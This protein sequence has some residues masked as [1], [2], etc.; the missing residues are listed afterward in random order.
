MAEEEHNETA[1]VELAPGDGCVV[2]RAAGGCE[3]L[4][5]A[6]PRG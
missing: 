4:M 5:P 3:F 6:I 2:M 1:Q